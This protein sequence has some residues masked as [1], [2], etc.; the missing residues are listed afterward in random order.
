MRLQPI[1]RP[2][3][4]F[5]RI[6]R[7]LSRRQLGKVMMPLKVVYPRIPGLLRAQ[8]GLLKLSQNGLSLEPRLRFLVETWVSMTNGCSFCG[9]LHEAQG[10]RAGLPEQ[11]F[12]S[13]PR[14]RTDPAFS[15]RE[16]AA[17]AAV[18]EIA[19]K[20]RWMKQPGRS[21]AGTSTKGRRQSSSGSRR[22]SATSTR[23]RLRSRSSPMDSA[24]CLAPLPSE[25]CP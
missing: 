11:L 13:L 7:W 9:D 2:H 20:R 19:R 3:S 10:L 24:R 21:C 6:A 8:L 17:L 18:E 1:E 14:F 12:R 4:L 22:S 16:R 15:A 23:W 5:L 25:A